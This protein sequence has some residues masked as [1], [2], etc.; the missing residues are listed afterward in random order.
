M[1]AISLTSTLTLLQIK[2]W[3]EQVFIILDAK[4]EEYCKHL[5]QNMFKVLSLL[6]INIEKEQL[7]IEFVT[8]WQA[9]LSSS[10]QAIHG[11]EKLFNILQATLEGISKFSWKA[12]LSSSL[13]A[14]HGK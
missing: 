13:E 4:M 1:G 9:S 7:F 5:V 3:K 10:L 2:H 11:K 8:T 6:S 14:I 12:L